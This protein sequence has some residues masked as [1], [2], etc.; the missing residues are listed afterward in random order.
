MLQGGHQLVVGN[1]SIDGKWVK[2]KKPFAVMTKRNLGQEEGGGVAYDLAGVVRSK[3]VF[4]KTPK[5]ITRSIL[6]GPSKR[7]RAMPEPC[8]G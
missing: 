2:L 3:L 4:N 6:P 8:L 5:P 7:T 1:A